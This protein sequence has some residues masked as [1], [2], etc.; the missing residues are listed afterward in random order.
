MHEGPE[1]AGVA[2][3]MGPTAVVRSGGVNV[4]L[5]TVKSMPG[6]LQ[7]LRSVGI[8]PAS[9]RILVVKASVRWRGGFEPIMAK[10]ILVDTPGICAIDLTSL[11]FRH[12]RRPIYP[13]DADTLLEFRLRT[14]DF[15]TLERALV[16]L[17]GG[18]TAKSTMHRR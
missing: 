2:A 10:G 15:L 5:T 6:D 3:E 7:Q 11:D 14:G 12:V 4:V 8:E 1:N 9:Q 17:G 16:T 18:T 13:L